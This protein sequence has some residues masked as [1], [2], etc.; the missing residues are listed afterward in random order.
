MLLI[1]ILAVG[2][3]GMF[4]PIIRIKGR[5][6]GIGLWVYGRI[7]GGGDIRVFTEAGRQ[8]DVA[9]G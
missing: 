3:L 4:E 9:G 8:F 2:T 1:R 6:I 7:R 5:Q